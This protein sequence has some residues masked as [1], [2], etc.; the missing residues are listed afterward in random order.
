[1]PASRTTAKASI[2]RSSMV[3]PF[4]RRLAE[5]DGLGG[6]SA[7]LQRVDLGLEH[8]DRR[9]QLGELLDALPSPAR[10]NFSNTPMG[11]PAYRWVRAG[12][13]AARG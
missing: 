13:W 9:D 11:A 8:V 12:Q 1:M 3:S 5:L 6:S 4:A 2:K 7:S 10:R